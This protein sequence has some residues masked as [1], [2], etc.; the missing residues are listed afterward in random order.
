[1]HRHFIA[2]TGCISAEALSSF[3]YWAPTVPVQ[4]CVPNL[5]TRGECVEETVRYRNC[6]AKGLFPR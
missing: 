5:W 3:I 1:M 6:A 2:E 4:D